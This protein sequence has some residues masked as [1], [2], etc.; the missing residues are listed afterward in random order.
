MGT[1]ELKNKWVPR[2]WSEGIWSWNTTGDDTSQT[3]RGRKRQ[4]IRSKIKRPKLRAM[5]A[6]VAERDEM[7]EGEDSALGSW[8]WERDIR[9]WLSRKHAATPDK[10]RRFCNAVGRNWICG[11][12][13]AG[14]VGHAIK[15]L[16][17]L[18]SLPPT[19]IR[20]ARFSVNPKHLAAAICVG[21]IRRSSLDHANERFNALVL[22][23][24]FHLALRAVPLWGP[25]VEQPYQNGLREMLNNARLKAWGRTEELPSSSGTSD[26]NS[27]LK[28]LQ[29]MLQL[30]PMD[31]ELDLLA[32]DLCGS[33]A[34]T[35][36]KSIN[37]LSPYSVD[38]LGQMENM[39]VF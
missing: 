12:A 11:L 1:T 7:I 13:D 22:R 15:M 37:A 4:Q 30:G 32:E 34:H 27:M 31:F 25:D 35:W 2:D 3:S 8:A 23:D 14:Y 36:L 24:R 21:W 28:S 29:H 26:V 19:S 18:V 17:A 9:G 38:D 20:G 10:I 6:Y 5:A 39:G 16:D 33:I